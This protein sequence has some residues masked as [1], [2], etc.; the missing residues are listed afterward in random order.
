MRTFAL[1][2]AVAAIA[3]SLP[4]P[5]NAGNQTFVSHNGTV[6]STCSA[7]QPCDSF[8][9]ALGATSP[10]GEINCLDSGNY[11]AV[12]ITQSVTIDCGGQIGAM[13]NFGITINGANIV[14][15]LRNL[16]I[17]GLGA[18]GSGVSIQ[19]AA[20]VIIENS[21]IENFNGS[22]S[23]GGIVINSA[24]TAV[25]LRNL[26]INGNGGTGTGIA[27][28]NAPVVTIE[29]CVIQDF[30]GNG[31]AGIIATN[32]TSLQL[33]IAD[34]LIANNSNGGGLPN[35]TGGI[36]LLPNGG[37]TIGFAFD[38]IHV[39][40]NVTLGI[41]VNGQSTTGAVTGVIRDS[42]ISGSAHS[43]IVAVASTVSLDHTHVAN[44]DI[45]VNSSNGAAVILNNSTVQVNNTGF[46]AGGGGAI[47]SYGNNAINGNQPGGIGTAPI[48]I[49][50]H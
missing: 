13:F 23:N 1:S 4:I 28:Q 26:T 44:N 36:I 49:G 14:V 39:E 6:N 47:F 15:K 20:A 10:S 5:A 43:G 50:F 11:G 45:G 33:N 18:S 25:T 9:T 31:G 8:A 37:G 12:M 48:V 24:N 42:V 32:S 29:N 21:L 2:I 35:Q 3:L 19:N 7:Q 27:I 34:T 17:N 22:G 40:N 30:S 38:R 41:D 46:S 16:I